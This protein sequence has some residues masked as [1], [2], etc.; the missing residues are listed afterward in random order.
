MRIFLKW[1]VAVVLGIALGIGSLWY[2]LF[3]MHP[4]AMV[5]NGV[6][7]MNPLAG[8]AAN[9][10]YSRLEIA[11]TSILALNKS[12]TIYFV[13]N[14]DAEGAA[15]T[16]AC[17]YMLKG[18]APDARWWS[19]TAYGPDDMLIHSQSERYSASMASAETN[20]DGAVEIALTQDGSGPNG[21]ATGNDGFVLLLRLYQPSEAIAAAP[22]AAPLFALTKGSCRS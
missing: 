9:D 10:P 21:I 22:E 20:A 15:L 6:W 11:I 18:P 14:A 1:L 5:A 17:D 12:E 13:A 4:T 7:R 19:V 3:R 2:A 16:A 8:S